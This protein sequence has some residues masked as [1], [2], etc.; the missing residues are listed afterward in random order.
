MGKTESILWAQRNDASKNEQL[1]VDNKFISKP[2]SDLYHLVNRKL[3]KIFSLSIFDETMVNKYMANSN[4]Q[5]F[6]L[7]SGLF[8][9]VAYRSCFVEKDETGLKEPFMFWESGL[10]LKKFVKD[11]ISSAS[12]L[13]KTLDTNEIKFVEKYIKRIRI[14]RIAF[15]VSAISICVL[16]LI[17][18]LVIL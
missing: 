15:C 2:D 14:R 6:Q 9:G 11:A 7:G 8:K 1:V 18:F 5:Y 12:A 13:G 17:L 3:L 16:M 4:N 10:R